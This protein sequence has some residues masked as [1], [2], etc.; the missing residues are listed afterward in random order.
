MTTIVDVAKRAGVSIATVSNVVNGTR[1]VRPDTRDRVLAAIA[2]TSYSQHAVARAL[3]RARTDTVGLVVTDTGQTVFA[4]MVRGV[5]HEA[6]KAGMVVLL[7]N[8]A[9]DPEREYD[10]VAALRERRVDGVLIARVAGSRDDLS[11]HLD[12]GK[13]PMVLLD[14]LSA[15]A[16][17]DQVGVETVEPMRALVAHLVANGHRDIAIV[18]GDLRVHTI[19]ERFEGYRLAMADAGIEVGPERVIEGVS[20]QEETRTAVAALLQRETAVTA[21]VSASNVL[22]A[23]TLLALRDCDLRVPDDLALVTFDEFPFADLFSPGLTSIVQ[24]AFAI[25]QE[26]MRL[27]RRRLEKPDSKPRTVRLRP[28]IAHR[29]SC[30]CD[31]DSPVEWGPTIREADQVRR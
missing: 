5:E 24:P 25:G 1:P 6:R 10:S 7:S 21:L 18:A 17:V 15:G 8:S 3:R 27:L 22:T 2:E 9:D 16:D 29:D 23:G 14:R 12:G 26:A 19:R 30:G 31:T 13:V 11:E 20:E 4:D 28:A